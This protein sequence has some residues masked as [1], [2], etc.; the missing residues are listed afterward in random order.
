MPFKRKDWMG[1]AIFVLTGVIGI[2]L[3]FVPNVTDAKRLTLKQCCWIVFGLTMLSVI[4]YMVQQ[5]DLAE[6]G[7]EHE[8]RN[9]ER[10]EREQERDRLLRQLVENQ[11]REL[12]ERGLQGSREYEA[13][14][15][16]VEF[17]NL[18]ISRAEARRYEAEE[19]PV[20]AIPRWGARRLEMK[21]STGRPTRL[22]LQRLREL[23]DGWT[24]SML[25]GEAAPNDRDRN[26]LS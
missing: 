22:Q 7:R 13:A 24:R 25:T 15:I 11:R 9:A 18:T 8:K 12:A 23:A 10:D 4:C 19:V 17:Y 1:L 6:E 21:I 2:F 26:T 14:R 5:R 3:A 16:A 20:R